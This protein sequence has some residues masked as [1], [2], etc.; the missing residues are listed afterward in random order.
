MYI[1][2]IRTV[3]E[4]I[5]NKDIEGGNTMNNHY[6]F[7]LRVLS[8]PYDE[9]SPII[10]KETLHFHH[11]K[12]LNTY[13]EN[14]NKALEPYSDFYTFSLKTLLTHLSDFP[15]NSQMA[16]RNN[17]GGVY[18]HELYFSILTNPNANTKPSETLQRAIERDFGGNEK[19]FEELKKV[20]LGRFG[21]GWAYIVTNKEGVLSICSTPNQ[22][23]PDLSKYLPLVTIDVWEHAYYLDYQNRRPDYFDSFITLINWDVVSKKYEDRSSCF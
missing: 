14:L 17:G 2:F 3:I 6:P 10:S 15:E 21:S 5:W 8:Y 19:M 9:L 18:N 12:H 1:C 22:D 13:V 20:A 11:D 4:F 7:S 16:V 23:V